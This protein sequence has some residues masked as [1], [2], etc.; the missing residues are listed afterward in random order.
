MERFLEPNAPTVNVAGVKI[1]TA[2]TEL[3]FYL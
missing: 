2:N 3:E 1:I